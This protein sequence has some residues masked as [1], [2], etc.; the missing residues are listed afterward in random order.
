M[1]TDIECAIHDTFLMIGLNKGTRNS[2]GY[3]LESA[4][5]GKKG[6]LML[7][8]G[9]YGIV[10]DEEYANEAGISR[11]SKIEFRGIGD[12]NGSNGFIGIAKNISVGELKFH[13]CVVLVREKHLD[14]GTEGMVGANLFDHFLVDIDF[15]K[16]RL[17][18]SPLPQRPSEGLA[19]GK[20]SFNSLKASCES[21]R[22]QSTSPMDDEWASCQ[23]NRHM[24]VLS[25]PR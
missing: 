7:D 22:G 2:W 5:N 20:M 1:R 9:A 3:G 13:D 14:A 16:Q 17:R 12:L 21:P 15:P 24:I 10:L 25:L 11:I 23:G 6:D 19:S 8:T 18:L 4:I